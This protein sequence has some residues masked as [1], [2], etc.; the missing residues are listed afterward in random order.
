MQ[1]QAKLGSRHEIVT[2]G[3]Y[4]DSDLETVKTFTTDIPS[5]ETAVFNAFVQ[6]EF[7]ASRTVKVTLGSK[8]EHQTFAG[9]GLL[10]SARVMWSIDPSQRAWASVSR[11]RRT[12]GAAYRGLQVYGGAIPGENG[13]P[14]VFRLVGNPGTRAEELLELEGGYRYQFGPSA[15]IDV[16]AFRGHYANST[17]LETLAPSFQ[18]SPAPAHVLIDLRYDDLLRVDTTGVEVS[19]HWMPLSKWRLDASYSTVHFTPDL[20]PAS[21]DATALHFDGNA[22]Q[23]QWQM[24][25]TTWLTP[26]L[27]LDGGLYY[28]GRLR[29]LDVPA[30]TRA[31]ARLEFKLTNQLSAIAVGQNLFQSAHTEFSAVNTA[32]VGS[33]VPRSGRVQLRWQF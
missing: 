32:L 9:W 27:E 26:R 25:S 33:R 30:Y 13:V 5:D 23:H 6:D 20:D 24:R 8:L 29:Q 10:P 16:T 12:P 21:N 22:P 7:S 18:L 28:V 31:D 2:G 14:V 3:G 17:T 4:R 1:Y 11:A 19:G 15:S